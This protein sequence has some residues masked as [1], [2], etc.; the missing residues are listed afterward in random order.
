MVESYYISKLSLTLKEAYEDLMKGNKKSQEA[1]DFYLHQE[2]RLKKLEYDILNHTLNPQSYCFVVK[3]PRPREIFA[4]DYGTR[5]LHHY[6][7]MRLRPILE[8]I[9][10][11]RS[12]NNREGMGQIACVNK[13]VEHIYD[14]SHGFTTDAYV[15]KV[16]LKGCFPNIDLNILY[17]KLSQVIDEYYHEW[18]K[19]IVLYLLRVCILSRPT[20]NCEIRC[21]PEE[22]ALIAPEKSI[23]NKPP[24]IGASPGNLIFQIGI[25]YYFDEIDRWFEEMGIRS[26]R[27][28]DDIIIVT[29]SKAILGLLPE[30]R[31]RLAKL[32]AQLNEKKFYH[33]HYT[34]GVEVLG[35]HIKMD[36]IYIN[37]RTVRRAKAKARLLNR[38]IGP[39][40]IEPMLASMNSYLGLCKVC[41]GFN[42]IREILSCLD[43]KWFKY[44]EYNKERGCLIP[45]LGYDNKNRLIKKY[46]IS[47]KVLS[48]KVENKDAQVDG[49][50]MVDEEN[51]HKSSAN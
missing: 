22:R 45:K 11:N 43:K 9:M 40:Y 48:P 19:D 36:R 21:S 15:T 42:K 14:A 8:K 32:G 46:G 47:Y 12:F 4:S 35:Y 41:N 5:L 20:E 24:G 34:K 31:K 39:N 49:D 50:D 13:V 6:L 26:V 1:L 25:N 30:L 38:R 2:S 23:F 37:N 7:D 17:N 16:D 29:E 51:K 28:V 27:Y 3:D 33:Q 10:T 18:D 44:V